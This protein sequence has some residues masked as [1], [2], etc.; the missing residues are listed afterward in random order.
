MEGLTTGWPKRTEN[1]KQKRTHNKQTER[2]SK[3]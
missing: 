3:S 2:R 1:G